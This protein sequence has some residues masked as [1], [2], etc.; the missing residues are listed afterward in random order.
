MAWADFYIEML[1]R[2]IEVKFR[3]RGSSMEGKISS[4]QLV[5]VTP[6]VGDH[7]QLRVGDIVLCVVEGNQ[8]LHLISEIKSVKGGNLYQI[9][10]NKGRI[11]GWIPRSKIY[12]KC[13]AV[14]N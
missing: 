12:G 9:S 8:Y 7:L 14:A 1:N 6:C 3:P 11:N 13:I 2:L 4:G 5:T 10:N